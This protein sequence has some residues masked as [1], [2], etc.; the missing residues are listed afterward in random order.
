M[1]AIFPAI[2]A[3]ITKH[4]AVRYGR[5]AVIA[6]MWWSAPMPDFTGDR[7][8]ITHHACGCIQRKADQRDELLKAI[9][10]IHKHINVLYDS[11]RE[12]DRERHTE[13][14]MCLVA[15]LS[16]IGRQLAA[17]Q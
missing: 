15:D 14:T 4:P 13:S 10:Q 3:R 11:A 7:E 17:L 2:T 6:S 12:L 5:L 9:G 1:S 16:A 8:C